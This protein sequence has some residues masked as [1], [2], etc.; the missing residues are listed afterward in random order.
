MNFLGLESRFI[1]SNCSVPIWKYDV[2][3][4]LGVAYLRTH[5][6][7]KVIFKMLHRYGGPF[8]AM[9]TY[10]SEFHSKKQ[11]AKIQIFRGIT[12]A[13]ATISLALIAWLFLPNNEDFHVTDGFG[14]YDQR[15]ILL[16]PIYII[17]H[18][19]EIF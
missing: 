8:A 17:V 3:G 11:R 15:Y 13:S 16:A 4:L 6:I 10:L 9:T 14:E 7:N 1:D 2:V 12:N 5:V 18:S 19:M